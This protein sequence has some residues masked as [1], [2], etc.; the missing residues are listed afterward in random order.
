MLCPRRR[1]GGSPAHIAICAVNFVKRQQ[2]NDY[3]NIRGASGFSDKSIADQRSKQMRVVD[4]NSVPSILPAGQ[5]QGK[6]GLSLRPYSSDT[7]DHR[8]SGR[9]IVLDRANR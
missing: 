4:A 5:K 2:E 7:P 8:L 3:Q 9:E 6:Q 1:T